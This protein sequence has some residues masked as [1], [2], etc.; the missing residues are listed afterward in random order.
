MGDLISHVDA[1]SIK[2]TGHVV[3]IGSAQFSYTGVDGHCMCLFRE[4]W[5]IVK[6]STVSRREIQAKIRQKKQRRNSSVHDGGKGRNP[7]MG[8]GNQ[9]DGK[10]LGSANR[11]KVRANRSV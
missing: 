5:K 11:G 7:K 2:R 4:E 9:E 10:V 3:W 6:R 8:T 1:H